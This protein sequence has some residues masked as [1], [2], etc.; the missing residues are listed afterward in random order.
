[1]TAGITRRRLIGG[2]A[3]AAPLAVL[4]TVLAGRP[5]GGAVLLVHDDTMASGRR[6]AA[7]AAALGTHSVALHGERVRLVRQLLARRPARVFGLTRHADHML[8]AEVA[9]EA[10]YEELASIQHREARRPRTRCSVA[11]E[12][13]A[14]LARAAGPCWPE[15]FAELALGTASGPSPL[16]PVPRPEP[17]F[18]WVLRPTA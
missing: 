13:L 9:G 2:A 16:R 18:S 10:G 5:A 4:G 8:F 17:A 12:T 1:M 7:H 6:F 15:A 14:S 3:A 11:A